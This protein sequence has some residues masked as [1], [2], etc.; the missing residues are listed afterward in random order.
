MNMHI[1]RLRDPCSPDGTRQDVPAGIGT[2][3]RTFPTAPDAQASTNDRWRCC[4]PKG[5]GGLL[6]QREELA[7]HELAFG[8]GRNAGEER[9]VAVAA[10]A[11][12]EGVDDRGP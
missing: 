9:L 6:K 1:R 3:R 12:L 11:V 2:P 4:P 8:D 10:R 5:L 7:G